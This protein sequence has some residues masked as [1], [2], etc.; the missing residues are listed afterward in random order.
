MQL[1]IELATCK[2]H[3]IKY[4][5]LT[6]RKKYISTELRRLVMM[7]SKVLTAAK[8]KL[9]SS[10]QSPMSGAISSAA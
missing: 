8:Q 3:K 4:F 5:K 9:F 10:G 6:V 2:N 1:N 7:A